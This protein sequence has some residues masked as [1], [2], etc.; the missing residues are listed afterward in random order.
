[1]I[2][3]LWT[4]G[5]CYPNPGPG[6]WAFVIVAYQARTGRT[7]SSR[8]PSLIIGEIERAEAVEQTTNSRMEL[9]A[10]IKGLRALKRPGVSVTVHS[11]SA[12]VVNSMSRGYFRTWERRG[13][14]TSRN[15]PVANRDLWEQLI[16]AQAPHTVTWEHVKGHSGIAYNERCDRLCTAA[17]RPEKV[18]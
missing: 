12:Y 16:A 1:M 5:G 11:D 18:A 15:E 2:V 17:Y 14:L 8:H 6:A 7:M 4:D 9:M 13:W 10:A 3:D